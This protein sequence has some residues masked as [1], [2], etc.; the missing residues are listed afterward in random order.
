[1]TSYR[2]LEECAQTERQEVEEVAPSLVDCLKN[3][4][5][6]R[7]GILEIIALIGVITTLDIIPK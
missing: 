7:F 3:C 5:T 6:D 4:V 2:C 1:M